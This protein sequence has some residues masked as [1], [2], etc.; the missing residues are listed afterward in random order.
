MRATV[1]QKCRG[2]VPSS[3]LHSTEFPVSSL[4]PFS[5]AYTYTSATDLIGHPLKKKEFLEVIVL[6]KKYNAID[7][8]SVQK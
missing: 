8:A 5:F 7:V 4:A 6:L 3:S 1:Q 2:N